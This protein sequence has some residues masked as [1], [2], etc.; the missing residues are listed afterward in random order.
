MFRG[1][2]PALCLL[3]GAL[4]AAPAQAVQ[5]SLERGGQNE[6]FVGGRGPIVKGDAAR[7]EQALA[8][9]PVGT[10]LLALALDSPGGN[11]LEGEQLARQIRARGL[12]V[13]IPSNSQCVSACFLLFAAA[14]H[15]FTATDALVGV[16]SAN[17][18][19]VETDIS[20]AVTTQM[21]RIAA[22]FGTPPAIIGKMVQTTPG[23]V[24]WLTPADM[25]LMGVTVFDGDAA[26]AVRQSAS[27]ASRPVGVAGTPAPV[28]Q[29][30]GQPAVP[31]PLPI[32][33]PARGA[34]STPVFAP[35]T[36]PKPV[37]GAPVAATEPVEAEYQGAYFCGNRPANLN[38]KLFQAAA[39]SRRRALFTFGPQA[40][41]PEIPRG[42]FEAEGILS[43]SGGDIV[44][45]P[46]KWMAQPGGYP[47]F[48][49][50]GRSEDGGKT[51]SGRV[52]DSPACSLFTF[53]RVGAAGYPR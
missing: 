43:V 30:V 47:W 49:L 16:H 52:T 45:K 33:P 24:E 26:A 42:S 38:L 41:S 31:P 2:I 22:S 29:P 37:S 27:A 19:G 32:L 9:V 1:I 8:S 18:A 51:F 53:K 21:A 15:R 11:V 12:S 14:V 44:M 23:R 48:G 28:G 50:N 17:E 20:L 5:F 25:T 39:D 34:A 7:L 4:W 3:A 10:K 35:A 6:A 40:T 36:T 13:L 46:S